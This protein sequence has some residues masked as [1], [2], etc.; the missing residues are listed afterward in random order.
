MDIPWE[1]RFA[2]R[3]EGVTSSAI[4]ELLKAVQQ[5]G[6]ISFGGGMPASELLPAEAVREASH[7]VLTER[8]HYALQYGLTEGYPPLQAWI[9]EYM[10]RQGIIIDESNVLIISGGQQ[11]LDLTARLLLNPGDRVAVESPTFLG[12]LQAFNAYQAA[13]VP[14]PMD[15]EGLE[16]ESLEAALAAG[17]CFVYTIPTF[18]NP[19]G[20]TLSQE[21]RQA[22]VELAAR[23]GVPILED[24]PYSQ[25]RYEGEHLPSLLAVDAS[26]CQSASDVYQGN[27]IHVGS[28]SKLLGP[29]LRLGWVVAP[30]VVIRRMV[31]AKQGIDVHTN[32]YT[33]MVVHEMIQD[34]FLEQHVARLRVVYRERRDLMLAAM[35]RYFPPGVSWTRPQGGLFLWVTLPPSLNAGELLGEALCHQVAF[36]P[37]TPF[38]AGEC[39]PH[40]LRL[41]FS[42]PRPEQIETGIQRLGEVLAQALE[43]AVFA[44]EHEIASP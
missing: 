13:Y 22:L 36:V 5:P 3:M 17:P 35:A 37:G 4:R 42:Y 33:Q 23:A 9:I 18:Q 16:I 28:F 27:V 12:A 29:G 38:Y 11:G 24:D 34:G 20:V 44:I 10:A 8:G 14:M 15:D 41:N 1:E 21:R 7:R 40:T 39:S 25:L 6:V 30:A 19:S 43:P 26:R 2:C 32:L 31:Q